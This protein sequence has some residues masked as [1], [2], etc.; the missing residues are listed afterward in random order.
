MTWWQLFDRAGKSWDLVAVR[1]WL[2]NRQLDRSCVVC[3]G[4]LGENC[5]S[6]G[7]SRVA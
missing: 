4:A 5:R 2:E 3:G 6:S 7:P 1:E